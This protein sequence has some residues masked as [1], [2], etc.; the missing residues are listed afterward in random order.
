MEDLFQVGSVGLIKAIDKFDSGRGTRFATFAVPVILGEIRNHFRDHGWAVKIPRKLQKNRVKVERAVDDLSQFLERS[1]KIAEIA[2]ATGLS[3]EEV[4]DTFEVGRYGRLLSLEAQY[5]QN[6]VSDVS[7][8]LDYLEG[9]DSE[10]EELPEKID[11]LK[12][13]G[14]L[15]ERERTIIRLK[16][17]SDLSQA[18]IATRL[19]ISQMHVSRLQRSALEQLK[20]SL[21]DMR[22]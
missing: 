4:Y 18:E 17:Y 2:E 14:H 12:T 20:L 3:Q 22:S 13:L 19:G 16:F 15:K 11:L 8:I 7:S 21:G 6:G 9:D 5:E 1:P 10:I